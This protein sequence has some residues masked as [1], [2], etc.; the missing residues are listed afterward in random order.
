MT[1]IDMKY[2]EPPTNITTLT[3]S[4]KAAIVGAMW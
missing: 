3:K 1:P 2:A 4:T